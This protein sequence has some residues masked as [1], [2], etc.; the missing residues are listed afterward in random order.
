MG[1]E[2]LGI[3]VKTVTDGGAAFRDGRYGDSVLPH[4]NVNWR[5]ARQL[6]LLLI[7]SWQQ[8]VQ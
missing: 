5:F 6:Y 3:F 4:P 2:K 1:L 8:R 7:E